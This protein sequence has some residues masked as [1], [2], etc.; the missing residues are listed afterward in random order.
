[1]KKQT[2]EPS[3][4]TP[5]RSPDYPRQAVPAQM[6]ETDAETG[7]AI[8]RTI[9]SSGVAAYRVIRAADERTGML[10]HMDVP[11]MLAELAEQA[12]AVSGGSLEQAEGMLMNQAVALQSLFVRLAERGM[13]HGSMPGFEANM[14][15]AMMAQRQ[16]ARALETLAVIKQGPTVI[17]RSANV[18]NGP[19][20]N[21]FGPG[22]PV[23]TDRAGVKPAGAG[24]ELLEASD[25]ERLDT[26]AQG[27]AG[28]ADTVLASVG[29][30]NRAGDA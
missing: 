1:M 29:A 26:R 25:G 16:C 14:R 21:N 28:R 3:K 20:Q 5:W 12:R 23:P 17:A 19:Q 6:G 18:V 30:V 27:T 11:T 13:G 24:N 2:K 4:Q 9:T 8:A 10:E 7:R 22:A 15:L